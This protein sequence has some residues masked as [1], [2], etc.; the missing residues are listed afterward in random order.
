[1]S[2][3]SS[4]HKAQRPLSKKLISSQRRNHLS[5][6]WLCDQGEFALM[7]AR[8]CYAIL[9]AEHDQ[10]GEWRVETVC[11]QCKKTSR[12]LRLELN[13]SEINLVH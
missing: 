10:F 3:G 8:G 13:T 9:E 7:T 6:D 12:H 11:A 2:E 5:L 4:W 1:M